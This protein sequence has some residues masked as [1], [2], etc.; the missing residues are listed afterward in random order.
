MRCRFFGAENILRKA[1]PHAWEGKT[2]FRFLAAPY[3][4]TYQRLQKGL[5]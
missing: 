1:V 4:I 5:A 2:D 3:S